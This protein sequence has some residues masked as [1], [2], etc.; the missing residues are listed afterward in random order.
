MRSDRLY[1]WT[2]EL[3]ENVYRGLGIGLREIEGGLVFWDTNRD[4]V[5][6][7]DVEESADGVRVNVQGI[8]WEFRLMTRERFYQYWISRIIEPPEF[9]TDEDMHDWYDR[10]MRGM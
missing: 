3:D 10:L 1:E 2:A 4:R 8:R 5:L 7:G 9:D 6:E